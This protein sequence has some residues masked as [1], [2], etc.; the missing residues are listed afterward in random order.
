MATADVNSTKA[1]VREWIDGNTTWSTNRSGN[2]DVGFAGLLYD[3]CLDL[4]KELYTESCRSSFLSK[5]EQQQLKEELGRLFLWGDAFGDGK[6]DRI[7]V[8][9]SDLRNTILEFISGIGKV[10][11][12]S[13]SFV[14]GMK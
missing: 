3:S 4:F 13:K 10:L 1:F 2:D 14:D 12:G 11:T 7:L 9:S 8:Q 6:L 5:D